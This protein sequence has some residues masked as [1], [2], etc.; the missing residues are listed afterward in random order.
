MCHS[1]A[2]QLEFEREIKDAGCP[3][4]ENCLG[5]GVTLDDFDDP[6]DPRYREWMPKVEQCN[7][8]KRWR[9]VVIAPQISHLMAEALRFDRLEK[10]GYAQSVTLTPIDWVCLDALELARREDEQERH[11]K[12]AQLRALE[13]LKHQ[14]K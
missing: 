7:H 3:R 11:K 10:Y 4:S 12:A 6:K 1:L 5:S 9:G 2:A 13:A 8:C 14:G